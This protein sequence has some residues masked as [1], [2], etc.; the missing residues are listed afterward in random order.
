MGLRRNETDNEEEDDLYAQPSDQDEP[1]STRFSSSTTSDR[2]LLPPPPPP[3]ASAPLP[4]SSSTK[5]K[6]GGKSGKGKSKAKVQ[7][8]SLEVDENWTLCPVRNCEA[9]KGNDLLAEEG[10]TKPFELYA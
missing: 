2:R 6:K 8:E 5:S 1:H 7:D 10:W 4:P 9:K 3:T